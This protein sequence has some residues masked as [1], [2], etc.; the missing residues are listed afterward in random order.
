MALRIYLIYSPSA[1]LHV[2][3]HTDGFAD[4]DIRIVEVAETNKL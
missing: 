3:N 2:P 1:P 4:A